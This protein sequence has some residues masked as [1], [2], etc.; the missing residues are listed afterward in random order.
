MGIKSFFRSCK[1]M[2]D[3][4]YGIGF[5]IFWLLQS[6]QDFTMIDGAFA[7]DAEVEMLGATGLAFLTPYKK[8]EI[9][10]KITNSFDE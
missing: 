6:Q 9:K 7:L 5:I 4:K 8:W 1:D 10:G 2:R 3:T